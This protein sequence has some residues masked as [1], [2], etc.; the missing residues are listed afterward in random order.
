MSKE[1]PLNLILF[2]CTANVCRS[3]MA[4]VLFRHALAAEKPP[5]SELKVASAGVFAS[6]HQPATENSCIAL[7]K[8]KLDL[9]PH[10]SQPL[11]EDLAHQALL[12]LGMTQTHVELIKEAFPNLPGEVRL[13]REFIP[14]N[15]Q[16]EIPDPFG[17]D[18]AIYQIC[19]DSMVEAIPP[20]LDYLR[21][22]LSVEK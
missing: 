17:S 8:V 19:R 9:S 11:T 15:P 2:V 12:I 16:I 1:T 14:N 10:R 21:K 13:M 4:E 22:K 5:L 7:K 3:P 6:A 18:L 20:L